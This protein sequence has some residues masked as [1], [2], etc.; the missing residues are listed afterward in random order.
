[1]EIYLL[2]IF[3]SFLLG[4]FVRSLFFS[5]KSVGNILVTQDEDG[6]Y[7]SLAIKKYR[8]YYQ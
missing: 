1:M 6:T 5:I 8:G 4:Y 7:L 2:L 3:T